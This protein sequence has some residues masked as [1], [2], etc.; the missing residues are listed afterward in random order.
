MDFTGYRQ[1]GC[2]PI[3][4]VSTNGLPLLPLLD[5]RGMAEDA[6][7]VVLVVQFRAKGVFSISRQKKYL[8]RATSEATLAE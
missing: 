1:I 6:A 8:W 5:S 7:L 2:F 3:V 4:S